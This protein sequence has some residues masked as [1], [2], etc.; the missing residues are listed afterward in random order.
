MANKKP[1]N[2][3]LGTNLLVPFPK[4]V[5]DQ[6]KRISHA[7]GV[8]NTMVVRMLIAI[9]LQELANGKELKLIVPRGDA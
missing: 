9:G 2:E 5:A 1:D 6:I 7:N 8:H 3:K 4:S